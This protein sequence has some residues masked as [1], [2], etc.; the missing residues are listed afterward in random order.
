M[1]HDP[2]DD[3]VAY[4][5]ST[6]DRRSKQ[7][8]ESERERSAPPQVRSG[9]EALGGARRYVDAGLMLA[10]GIFGLVVAGSSS[11]PVFAVLLSIFVICYSVHIALFARSYTMPYFVYAFAVLGGAWLLFG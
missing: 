6:Y 2:T 9:A 8:E 3:S 11:R 4:W 7:P 1:P 5:N 10:F